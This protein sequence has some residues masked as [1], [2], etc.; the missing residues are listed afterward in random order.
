MSD[1][2]IPKKIHYCWFGG[3]PLSDLA[4]KCIGSWKK[5]LP[6]YEIVEWNESNFDIHSCDYV[7]QAYKEKKWAFVSDY[8]RFKILYENGG[9]YFDTDVEIINSFDKIIEKGAFMGCE[10]NEKGESL[11]NP[12]IGL[13]AY[14]RMD[15]YNEILE[16]YENES[17][18]ING[19]INYKTVVNR[20]TEVLTKYGYKQNSSIQRVREINVYP[21]DFFCPMD[22]A[23]GEL[24]IT[25]NTKS[26]H[27]YDASWLDD[28]MQKRREK[29]M[30]IRKKHKGKFSDFLCKI[31]MK[32]SYGFE[33]I[34]KR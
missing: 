26:V 31:Y 4:K 24:N 34:M 16:V 20:T 6:E 29:C 10:K 25:D 14:P 21:W 8:A 7:E 2:L 13:A 32:F 17:F 22:Y 19:K 27:W 23:T 18:I 28:K 30:K 33:K 15:I 11:V 5:Y 12:G 3:N 9:L 1:Y